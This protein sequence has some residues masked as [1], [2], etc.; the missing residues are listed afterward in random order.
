MRVCL[1][2]AL[3]YSHCAVCLLGIRGDHCATGTYNRPAGPSLWD[4]KALRFLC[5]RLCVRA[6][7]IVCIPAGCSPWEHAVYGSREILINHIWQPK[8]GAHSEV[9][10]QEVLWTIL[11]LLLKFS[12]EV[13]FLCE[14]VLKLVKE[15]CTSFAWNCTSVPLMVATF[16]Q[17]WS[18][19]FRHCNPL[20]ISADEQLSTK[21]KSS[22]K[23]LLF[24][25][26]PDKCLWL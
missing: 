8:Q 11:L 12:C 2:V 1:F 17:F 23:C 5:E 4:D 14:C 7:T 21:K 6:C 3:G 16:T 22:I 18:N 9:A 24:K 25:W 19:H 20:Q 15:H 10:G 13:I 26:L